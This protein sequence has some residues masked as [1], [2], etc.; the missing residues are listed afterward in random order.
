MKVLN[1]GVVVSPQP[2][3]LHKTK[4]KNPLNLLLQNLG[5]NRFS[6]NKNNNDNKGRELESYRDILIHVRWMLL[7]LY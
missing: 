5:L 7:I 2:E 4:H 6:Y 3:G 1:R